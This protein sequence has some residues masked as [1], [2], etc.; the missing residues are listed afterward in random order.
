MREAAGSGDCAWSCSSL[1]PVPAS[2][3][4][5]SRPSAACL[6]REAETLGVGALP[7]YLTTIGTTDGIL[8]RLGYLS[9]GARRRNAAGL[10][11]ILSRPGE[12]AEWLKAAPC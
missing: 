11:D 3:V 12:V 8:E 9:V 5:E 6:P 2:P 10:S 4:L 7:T 1:T